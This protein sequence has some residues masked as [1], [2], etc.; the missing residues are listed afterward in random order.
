MSQDP[1]RDAF[2]ELR[3]PEGGVRARNFPV[4]SRNFI[5]RK[6]DEMKRKDRSAARKLIRPENA[7]AIVDVFPAPGDQV[8]GITS[9]DFV[10]GDLIGQVVKRFGSPRRITISTLS[11]SVKNAELLARVLESSVDLEI[12]LLISHYFQSTN[13]DIFRAIESLLSEKFPGRFAVTV[14]RSH[15]KILL[16]DYSASAWV[17]ETSANLR[18]SNNI[19][20]F[21]ISNDRALLDFHR[22]WILEITKGGQDGK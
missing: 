18:S 11:L 12:E 6:K 3:D 4:K 5:Q 1:L 14:G 21:V 10:M 2:K 7:D 16:F 20:Q 19:E 22:G 17:V 15:A 9:G 13:G 8:H